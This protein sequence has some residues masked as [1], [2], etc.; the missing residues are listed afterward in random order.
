MYKVTI[1][2]TPADRVDWQV[3]ASGRWTPGQAPELPDHSLSPEV[4]GELF[5]T[6]PPAGEPSSRN[7]IQWG[8]TLYGVVFRK[9]AR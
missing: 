8:G 4:L 7:Q 6:P 2:S 5:K 9:L 1:Q 3:V